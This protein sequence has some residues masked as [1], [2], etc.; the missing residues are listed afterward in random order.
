ME[1]YLLKST[2]ALSSLYAFYWFFLRNET[3][4]GWNRIY[5]ISSL[6]VSL[7]LP[8]IKI[9]IF[10]DVERSI[11]NLISP[12]VISTLNYSNSVIEKQSLSILSI[13]YISGAVFFSLKFISKLSQIY[14]LYHRF[15][16]L[17]FNGF[18]AVVLD[19]DHSPFTFF[20]ILFLSRSD[21]EKGKLTEVLVHEKA[22]KDQFHSVDIIL[23]E[24]ITILQWFNPFIWLF[25]IAIK[26]EHEF[27]ADEKVLKEGYDKV[28]YQRLLFEKSL[29]MTTLGVTSNFNYSLLKNRIKMMTIKKSSSLAKAKYIISLPLFLA[30]SLF[31]TTNITIFAQEKAITDFD[32]AP[33]YTSEEGIRGFIA[34]N[35][36]YP[37]SAAEQGIQGKV[38][39]NFVVSENGDV[40]DVKV[41]KTIIKIKDKSGN[42]LDQE[43]IAGKD[44]K[45]DVA[46][47]DMEKEAIR[48]TSQIGKFT[49]G[50]KNN[51]EVSV[52]YTFPITFIL[53]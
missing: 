19:G 38:Y 22:H 10:H 4:F 44:E 3:Y 48:V 45:R 31:L 35:M 21:F 5:L 42:L 50:K 6:L 32:Q 25:R 41:L 51:K 36:K 12:A 7:V 15:P 28:T 40:K 9:S 30:L 43:Y 34:Q 27:I 8:L 37:E 17:K 14:Y 46:V 16:K 53:Q 20:S 13:I 52:Q 2:I 11:G 24:L 23:L 26:S 39:V 18:K 47:K 1:L 29:G 33:V 49:P